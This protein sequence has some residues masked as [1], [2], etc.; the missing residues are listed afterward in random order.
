MQDLR[1][2]AIDYDP[3]AVICLKTAFESAGVSATTTWHVSEAVKLLKEEWFDVVLI[4]C[5]GQI[6]TKTLFE[7]CR[8]KPSCSVIAVDS[9]VD[10]EGI[11]HLITG[12]KEGRYL[13][14]PRLQVA[15]VAQS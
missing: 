10:H 9:F 5:H 2:L 11:L 13:S 12:S 1:V 14:V 15:A 7:Y 6:D 4:R 3:D 8:Q